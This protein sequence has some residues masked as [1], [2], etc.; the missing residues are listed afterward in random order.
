M[1]IHK[2]TQMTANLL[3]KTTDAKVTKVKFTQLLELNLR[4]AY[5]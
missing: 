5:T 3:Q 4:T 2:L 1:H